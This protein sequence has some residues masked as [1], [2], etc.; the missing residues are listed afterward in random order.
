MTHLK[1]RVGSHEFLWD[2]IPEGS[3]GRSTLT[4]QGHSTKTVEVEWQRYPGKIRVFLPD[5]VMDFTFEGLEDE[6]GRKVFS[7][8]QCETNFYFD[9]LYFLEDGDSD[10]ALGVKSKKSGTRVRA[11]MPGKILRICVKSGDPVEKDQP[12]FVM[13]AMKMENEIRASQ[14]G[15]IST[16]SLTEGQS[17]ETGFELCSILPTS[18]DS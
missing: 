15:I 13:E 1:G 12:M 10:L 17:V 18:P 16:F 3:C 8:H 4:L 9:S 11:Q 7:L 5:H 14:S 6:S 2:P